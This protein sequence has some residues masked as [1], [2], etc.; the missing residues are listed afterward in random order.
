MSLEPANH[1]DKDAPNPRIEDAIWTYRAKPDP[2]SPY[3][4]SVYDGDTYHIRVDQGF[5]GHRDESLRAWHID[6]AE[7]NT[8]RSDDEKELA[9]EQRDFARQW[10]QQRVEGHDGEWP[11]IVRTGKEQGKYGRWLTMVFDHEG[12]SLEEDIIAEYGEEYLREEFSREDLQH[13]FDD[14]SERL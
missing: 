9:Y 7:I 2:E 12:N 4:M 6:T 11:L 3:E 8:A 14:L 5:R 10:I 1:D 13:R